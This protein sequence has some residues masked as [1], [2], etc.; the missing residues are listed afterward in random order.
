MRAAFQLRQIKSFD[1]LLR[2]FAFIRLLRWI[3]RADARNAAPNCFEK[4]RAPSSCEANRKKRGRTFH[5]LD[6]RTKHVD[7]DIG[8][9]SM[10]FLTLDPILPVRIAI[11]RNASRV[12]N[13][14]FSAPQYSFLLRSD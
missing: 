4:P 6:F 7:V 2:Q 1:V 9:D 3:D 13:F 5:T 8:R 14:P 12:P 10:T 11:P